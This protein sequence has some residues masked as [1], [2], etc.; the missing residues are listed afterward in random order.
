MDGT[1]AGVLAGV[2]VVAVAVLA[3]VWG[4]RRE[5]G[6]AAASRDAFQAVAAD[7][8]DS[9][10]R[11]FLDLAETRFARL[12][13]SAAAQ[14]AQRETAIR[15]LVEPVTDALSR[16]DRTLADIEKE[17]HGQFSAL[18]QQ[19]TS[20]G[21]AE[22]LLRQETAQL[23]Q[24]MRSP[25][26]RG[27]WGELQLR[28]VVE[29]AGL[30]EHCDFETQAHVVTDSGRLRP[31]LVVHLPGERV[32]V[33]DA[34]TP[35][36]AYLA[37][38]EAESDDERDAAWRGHARQVRDHRAKLASKAYWSQFAHSPEFVVMFLPGEAFFSAAVHADPTLLDGTAQDAQV[39]LASPTTLIALLRAVAHGWRQEALADNARELS[40]TAHQLCER[41]AG[42]SESLSKV[43]RGL[44]SAVD[45]Y[46]GAI[47]TWDSRVVVSARR[48]GE[49][50]VVRAADVPEL[51]PVDRRAREAAGHDA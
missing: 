7:A 3:F 17:R 4:A 37:M 48:L 25:G 36:D 31:D 26:V 1:L 50:G 22:R 39:I 29:L 27:R 34:K 6:S 16:V 40:A 24:A 20:L 46:N 9:A 21:E 41:L 15:G 13:D 19:I 45:A 2:V 8:L 43:G 35:L 30:T 12:Q 10:S 38:V 44:S 11:R 32:V 51:P 33:V 49:L 18:T 42:F 14:L 28:R 23:A 5:R 47:G